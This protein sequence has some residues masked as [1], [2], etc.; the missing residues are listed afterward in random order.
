L[1]ICLITT[2]QPSANPRLVK[3]ADAL[4]EAGHGVHVVAAHRVN[5]ATIADE[6]LT[7]SRR[8]AYTFVDWRREVAP[9]LFWKTRVRHHLARQLQVVPGLGHLSLRAAVDRLTPELTRAALTV[10]ADLYVAHN[11]GA[12]PAAAAAA[13]AHS[14]LLG[15][16]AEDYHSGEFAEADRSPLRIAVE[17]VEQRFIPRCDY[18]TAA[19]D[20]IADAYAPLSRCGRPTPI[21]NVFSLSSRPA[22]YREPNESRPLALYWFS[23]TIGPDRGLEDIVRA[24]GRLPDGTAEL[25]LRGRW[26][27]GYA[28][29]LASV[30]AEAGVDGRR[31]VSYAPADSEEMVRLAAAFDIGLA[32]ETG[33]TQNR[34]IAL[35]NK[36]FTYLLAGIATLATRTRAQAALIDRLGLAAQSYEPGDIDGA[37]AALKLWADDRRLLESS[38]RAA[39]LA[40]ETRYNWD[41]EKHQ[42]LHVIDRVFAHRPRHSHSDGKTLIGEMNG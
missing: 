38:R 39:W 28:E 35:T 13:S 36:V 40:G 31:I 14:G 34:R 2:S 32:T 11:P 24:M 1:K 25:H 16:D 21:L 9:L 37:A 10:S 12:L 26:H 8:W 23:Q 6:H 18:I 22:A 19:A 29:A 30:A 3:E 20:G 27:H 41:T 42:Y 15:F 4:V 17:R 33:K 7:A 5:W